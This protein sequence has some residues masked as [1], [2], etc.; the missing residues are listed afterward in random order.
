MSIS[1]GWNL[2]CLKRRWKNY[3][4][5]IVIPNEMHRAHETDDERGSS[6]FQ[7]WITDL[8]TTSR[9]QEKAAFLSH[10]FSKSHSFHHPYAFP[11][12][13]RKKCRSE[14]F[15]HFF[16]L[17]FRALQNAYI[18]RYHPWILILAQI[19]VIIVSVAIRF[20]RSPSSFAFFAFPCI[21]T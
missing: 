6:Q 14:F 11:F 4:F 10:S 5:T 16:L 9:E 17:L 13:E 19:L 20:S 21:H 3:V 8:L 1:F 15:L 18:F 7:L 12:L 2:F